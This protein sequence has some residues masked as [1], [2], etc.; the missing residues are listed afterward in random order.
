M[1][2]AFAEIPMG[3]MP[4]AGLTFLLVPLSQPYA[5][6]TAV[7]VDEFGVLPNADL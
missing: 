5:G 6:P 2:A 7:L 1:S 3:R 4:P